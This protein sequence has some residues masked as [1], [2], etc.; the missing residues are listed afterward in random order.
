MS[1]THHDILK[2]TR[3]LANDLSQDDIKNQIQQASLAQAMPE[4]ELKK[5]NISVMIAVRVSAMI[6]TRQL[7]YEIYIGGNSF[8]Q[9]EAGSLRESIHG[10]FN[11]LSALKPNFDDHV[12][13]PYLNAWNIEHISDIQVIPTNNFA[14]H[15]LL[16]AGQSRLC[17]FH[18]VQF[19]ERMRSVQRYFVAKELFA[20][21]QIVI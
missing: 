19:L 17:I 10:H 9:W 6:N 14:D 3:L 12:I 11:R 5:F 8:V 13:A 1:R 7:P 16:V 15:L 21:L 2:I 20:I 18:H 4:D